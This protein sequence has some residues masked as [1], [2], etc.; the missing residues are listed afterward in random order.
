MVIALVGTSSPHALPYGFGWLVFCCLLQSLLHQG[1]IEGLGFRVYTIDKRCNPAVSATTRE[2]TIFCTLL[3]PVML[4][5][6][7]SESRK[8]KRC[9]P[10]IKKCLDQRMMHTSL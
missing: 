10:R 5:N 3:T 4:S 8:L 7:L 1:T 6:Q 2:H 9:I